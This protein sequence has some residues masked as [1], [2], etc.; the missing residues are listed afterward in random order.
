MQ[1]LNIM[2]YSPGPT[3]VLQRSLPTLP[4]RDTDPKPGSPIPEPDVP[5]PPDQTPIEPV[6]D[7]NPVIPEH[8]PQ[9]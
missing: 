6:K 3:T 2:D 8:F 5:F 4:N 1:G 7:P 9:K